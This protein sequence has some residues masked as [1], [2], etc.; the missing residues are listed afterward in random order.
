VKDL[1]F[2]AARPLQPLQP[3]RFELP[4]GLKVIL[5]EDHER[6]VVSAEA[7]IRTGSIFDPADRP[8]LAAMT[9]SLLRAGG[10]GKRAPERFD[11]DL[12][13][14]GATIDS[15]IGDTSGTVTLSVGKENLAEALALFRDVLTQPD[16][17]HDRI[18]RSKVLAL[19]AIPR[20]NDD[21]RAALLREFRALLFGKDSPLARRP[22]AQTVGRIGRPDI[23]AFYRRYFFPK[24]V[25]LAISGDF[26]A[27]ALKAAVETL[28]SGWKNDQPTVDLPKAA[29]ETAPGSYVARLATINETRFAVGL[30]LPASSLEDRAALEV[31]AALVGGGFNGRL[32]RR[33][34]EDLRAIREVHADWVESAGIPGVFL[35]AGACQS[36][37]AGEVVQAIVQ[38]MRRLGTAEI[39]EDELRAARELAMT[40]AVVGLDNR[41]RAL[42]ALAKAETYG[43]PAGELPALYAA[44]GAVTRADVQKIAQERLQPEKMTAL[45]LSNMTAWAQPVDPRGGE[46]KLVDIAVPQAPA[47]STA[48]DP[49]AV[50]IAK[51]LLAR[52]QEASGGVDKL[53][54]VKDFTQTA[55][56]DVTDGSR[57]SQTDRWLA[58][59]HLRQD[60]QTRAG[61]IYRYTDGATGWLSNGRSST[62]LTGLLAKDA[63][64]ETLRVYVQLLISDR[65]PGRTVLALDDETVEIAQGDSRVQVVFDLATGLPAKLLYETDRMPPTFVEEDYSDF[66]DVSGVKIPFAITVTQNGSKYSS[67]TVSEFKINQGLKVEVL[68]RRP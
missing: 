56:Y 51:K 62:S 7:V 23:V 17:R 12:D 20:R 58:P 14:L 66:R 29:P 46:P 55:S 38:E 21:P 65:L 63:H 59:S 39:S 16:F 36:P 5:S 3:A 11:A 67:G 37:S 40:S 27:A 48:A 57:E 2:P 45:L 52:A 30:T 4:N 33:S 64:A 13:A 32:V 24:N 49:A 68:Q 35:I 26:D 8:G 47:Q 10:T 44:I 22:E 19:A 50:E 41:A 54:A 42:F 6:P 25:T 61:T 60:A 9:G 1:K 28:F 34:R 53:L 31:A 43:A 18:D 15:S